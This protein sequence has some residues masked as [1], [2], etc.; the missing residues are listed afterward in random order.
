MDDATSFALIDPLVPLEAD[1]LIRKRD[2]LYSARA[3][4]N[5]KKQTNMS[6][7]SVIDTMTEFALDGVDVIKTTAEE[8]VSQT[9]QGIT[10]I[11]AFPLVAAVDLTGFGF[12]IFK[13]GFKRTNAYIVAPI[14]RGLDALIGKL[15]K[16]DGKY[17]IESGEDVAKWAATILLRGP[18]LATK[19]ILNKLAQGFGAAGRLFN[20]ANLMK[21]KG[22]AGVFAALSVGSMLGAYFVPML[23]GASIASVFTFRYPFNSNGCRPPNICR[24]KCYT[25]S[26]ECRGRT[27]QRIK[28][29]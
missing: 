3:V 10:T 17:V 6:I 13:E 23:I 19:Y 26:L 9:F 12:N 14:E 8:A 7:N 16:K 22:I 1:V 5:A 15:N 21:N 25:E 18:I 27:S 20:S 24:H 29:R 4:R 2:A 11:I 28:R